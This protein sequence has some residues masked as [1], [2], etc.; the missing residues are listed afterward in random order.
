MSEFTDSLAGDFANMLNAEEFAEPAVYS[1]TETGLDHDL[2]V[3]FVEAH[4]PMDLTEADVDITEPHVFFRRSDLPAE[5]ILAGDALTVRGTEW[6]VTRHE[7]DGL[8]GVRVYVYA[9]DGAAA[10]AAYESDFNDQL[11]D[12]FGD[13]LNVEEFAQTVVYGSI[14]TGLDYNFNAIFVE[15]F[16]ND[17][18]TR[19]DIDTT[20]PHI[21]FRRSDLPAQNIH[22]GD[23]VTTGGIAWNVTRHEDD[24]IGGV[25]VYLYLADAGLAA[26]AEDSDLYGPL[27]LEEG[28]V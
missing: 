13:M 10:S 25:R 3:I 2:D 15:A 4:E 21:I 12:D 9:P 5:N 19:A 27:Q 11:S 26:A 8:G 20:E 22:R 18:L 14:E 17:G 7:D 16:E 24:G 23:S 1:S 28:A 6:S